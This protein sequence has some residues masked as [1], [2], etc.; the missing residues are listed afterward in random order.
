M[1]QDEDR[2][3]YAL[4]RAAHVLILEG[5]ERLNQEYAFGG[6]INARTGKLYGV[7][8]QAYAEWAA[9][10]GK[11]V[12]TDD[13]LS[14][15]VSLA[16]GIRSHAMATALLSEGVA[17]S[18]V[19]AD[20]CG[21]P[22]QTRMDWFSRSAGIVDLKTCDDLTRFE[23]DARRFGH[24]YQ[25][26]FYRA[27]LAVVS[28]TVQPV[29]LIAVEKREPFRCGVWRVS[30]QSLDYCQKENEAAIERLKSCAATGH[31]PTC[32]EE[33]RVFDSF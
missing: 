14:L 17:E 31:W 22:C 9:A 5:R 33:V 4:G 20:Y 23:A 6:P 27:V 30:E 1:F 29:H 13:Q 21:V 10:Q 25:L 7:N 24:A 26:A 11:P 16:G 28:G 8:T 18:V 19:R 2:P 12:L 3:A 15:I 32:Y